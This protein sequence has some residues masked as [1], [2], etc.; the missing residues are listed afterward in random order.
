[1]RATYGSLADEIIAV[2]D[3]NHTILRKMTHIP[4]ISCFSNNEAL[5]C[6]ADAFT[7]DYFLKRYHY[8]D[9][10]TFLHYKISVV[11]FLL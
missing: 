4:V 2:A 3:T 6:G 9:V 1:M 5:C 11:L 8:R 7:L 10:G